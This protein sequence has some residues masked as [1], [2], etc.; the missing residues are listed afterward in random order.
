[1]QDQSGAKA[2]PLKGLKWFLGLALTVVLLTAAYRA[3]VRDDLAEL[4]ALSAE[5]ETTYIPSSAYGA[6]ARGAPG[7]IVTTFK[8]RGIDRAKLLAAYERVGKARGWHQSGYGGDNILFTP[9]GQTEPK[10]EMNFYVT[11][12]SDADNNV[13]ADVKDVRYSTWR[14]EVQRWLAS[15]G[16]STR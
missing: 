12:E 1:M 2:K 8:F 4:K 7:I 15:K 5:H 11:M 10:A 16:L 6:T 3:A 14:D 9:V 13:D